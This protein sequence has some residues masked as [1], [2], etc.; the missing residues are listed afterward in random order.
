VNGKVIALIVE[1]EAAFRDQGVEGRVE[2]ERVVKG[3]AG[4][5]RGDGDGNRL[6][7]RR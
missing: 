5:D 3:Q 1:V 2:T 7:G 4:G 6:G